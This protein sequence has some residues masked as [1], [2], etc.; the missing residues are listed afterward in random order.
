VSADSTEKPASISIAS[1]DRV[2]VVCSAAHPVNIAAAIIAP[3]N[4]SS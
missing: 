3:N 4:A 1:L 2:P